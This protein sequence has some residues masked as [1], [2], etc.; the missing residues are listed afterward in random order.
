MP[1]VL[2]TTGTTRF[3][4]LLEAADAL[5]IDRE[6]WSFRIQTGPAEFVPRGSEHFEFSSTIEEEYRTA[7]L[8]ITHAGAG[9]LFTLA[10]EGI[11]AIAVPNLERADH[12]QT[13][14]AEYFAERGYCLMT[15]EPAELGSLLDEAANFRPRSFE[16]KS[17][18]TAAFKEGVGIGKTDSVNILATEGGHLAQAKLLA[19]QLRETGHDGEVRVFTD[20]ESEDVHPL[21]H[22]S[23]KELSP[24]A[25]IGPLLGSALG[26][27]ARA[28]NREAA[29]ADSVIALGAGG[30]IPAAL[31]AKLRR[32]NLVMLESRSRV[33]QRSLTYRLLAPLSRHRVRQYAMEG[34]RCYGVLF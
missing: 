14:L 21:P 22:F 17:F 5:A 27:E 33:R 9:T 11:P 23:G 2:V 19:T 8:V 32:R 18:D 26:R 30:C 25:R 12:H 24:L 3:L 31:V 15:S 16:E 7:D 13:E 34:S 6:D 10:R 28:M 20:G 4:G 1:R 29:S